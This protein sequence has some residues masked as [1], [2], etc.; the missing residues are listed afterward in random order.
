MRENSLPNE[1]AKLIGKVSYIQKVTAT[2][3][4]SSCPQCG[5]SPHKNGILPDRFRMWTNAN[6]KNKIFGWCRKCGYMFFPE[7][8]KPVDR[9]E[10]ERWRNEQIA[11]EKQRKAD[12][13][14]AI[15]L[16]QSQKPWLAY[17]ERLNQWALE[18]LAKRGLTKEYAD[19]WQLG[20]NPD[21]LVNGIYHSPALT[22]PL[23]QY[24]SQVANI[25]LRILNP[26]EDKDRYR[27]LYKTGTAYP[28]VAWRDKE[29]DMCLIVEG[30]FKAMACAAFS[31]KSYQV[32]G[33]PTKIPSQEVV[34]TLAKFDMVIVCLDPDASQDESL[35]RLVGMLP[36][37]RVSV[38]ELPGK[39][40]DML[41]WNGL[42]I[43]DVIKYS[44]VWR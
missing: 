39:I 22:I 11:I 10:F 38:A 34:N 6:G 9:A 29:S 44:K 21:Y 28:F 3:Y 15:A 42:Q 24:D 4:S 7:N 2:E 19:Y 5:G 20:L 16:L 26:K 43:A 41:V 33:L 1:F 17:H 35:K 32:V 40:D 12:A 31:D 37:K 18:I 23:W 14:R 13:E 27:Q 36:N 30:E 8:T 25:K